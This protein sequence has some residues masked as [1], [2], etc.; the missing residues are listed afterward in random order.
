MS[1]HTPGPCWEA[2]I[3]VQNDGS[4]AVVDAEGRRV[5]RVDA[6][7][8]Q[9]ANIY[10]I[11]AAPELLAALRSGEGIFRECASRLPEPGLYVVNF[12]E[13]QTDMLAAAARI[14]AVIRKATGD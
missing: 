8:N 14:R 13:L 4:I 10:L 3:L 2:G 6:G 5:A 1:A 11:A 7:P 9:D 12:K